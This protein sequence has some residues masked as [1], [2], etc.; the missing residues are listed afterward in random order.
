MA[1]TVRTKDSA[2]DL[3]RAADQNESV[4]NDIFF[5]AQIR[6]VVCVVQPPAGFL[7][8]GDNQARFHVPADLNGMNL[9]VCH[10]FHTT[11][12]AG[13]SPSLIQV[14]NVTQAAD[15][16]STRIMIDVGETDST[17][18]ATAYVINAAEDDVAT[19][20]IIAIDYD[21][22]PTTSPLGLVVTLGFQHP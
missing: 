18:A 1:Y 4:D 7:D 12:G 11:A 6:Y 15:M 14:R 2:L 3:G 16:L 13:G 5:Y 21:Q 8:T 19:N 9:V 20:D 10:A 17:T 22:R